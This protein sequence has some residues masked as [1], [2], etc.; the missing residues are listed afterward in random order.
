MTVSYALGSESLHLNSFQCQLFILSLLYTAEVSG[1]LTES[2]FQG[3]Q[4]ADTNNKVSR[5]ET[6]WK[7]QKSVG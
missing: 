1:C 6:W 5:V 4:V 2:I 7:D 3:F